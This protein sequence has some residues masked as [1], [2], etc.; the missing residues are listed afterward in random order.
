MR[1]LVEAIVG[2]KLKYFELDYLPHIAILSLY[3]WLVVPYTIARIIDVRITLI[4]D[5]LTIV[6]ILLMLLYVRN[7]KRYLSYVKESICYLT[8]TS[9]NL[10]LRNVVFMLLLMAIH[11]YILSLIHI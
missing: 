5:I 6:N 8:N 1:K 10:L 4:W 11:V 9:T 3:I 2:K 7:I